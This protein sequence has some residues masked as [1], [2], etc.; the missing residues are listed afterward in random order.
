MKSY[1]KIRLAVFLCIMM[2]LPSVV[3][4]LPMTAQETSAAQALYVNW[5]Y[6]ISKHQNTYIQI[7]KGA[8][9]YIGDYVYIT[10]GDNSGTATMFSKAKYSSSKKSVATVNSK[11]LLTAKKTGTTVIKVK[12]KGK[13]LS[14]KF[15][16]VKAGSLSKGD[17]A[18]G[19]Q[20]A[21]DK[22]K[23]SLPSKVTT[24][25]ALKYTKRKS[26]YI[27]AAGKYASDIT[28]S[29]FLMEEVI[30]GNY[31][32]T[33]SSPKLAVPDAG[34]A[35]YLDYVLYK[36][37]K[38]NSPTSTSS[39]KMIKI[40][41]VS[42]TTK[43]ITIKIKKAITTEQILAANIENSSYNKSPNKKSAVIYVSVYD[44]TAE[45]FYVGHGTIKKGSKTIKVK[46]TKNEVNNGIWSTVDKKLKKGHTYV[47]GNEMSW[48]K[49][50]KVKV[51]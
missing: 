26:N 51:K 15:K 40:S 19:L 24:S 46:L 1:A 41:S 14:Q 18:K 39:S 11:G 37:S 50:K 35:N 10:D 22:L 4:V 3:S 42:A 25:T 16:V 47:L 7:E 21:A 49:G 45:E 36:Y 43:E 28:S 30:S 20:K 27:T 12:Y 32:Y 2:V 13:T 29:G 9:F 33:T 23:A 5:D 6:N 38:K 34:R 17:A 48:E 44:K 8:K 31:S